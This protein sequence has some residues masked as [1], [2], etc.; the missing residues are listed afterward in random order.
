M[1]PS[2]LQTVMSHYKCKLTLTLK[3][4]SLFIEM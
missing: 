2:P 4:E 1:L 3:E